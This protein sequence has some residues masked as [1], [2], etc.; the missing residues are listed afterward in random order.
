M[1]RWKTHAVFHLFLFVLAVVVKR[2]CG[3]KVGHLDGAWSGGSHA[4]QR[5]GRA[6]PARAR[7]WH[8]RRRGRGVRRRRGRGR[9]KLE[10]GNVA[11]QLHRQAL[12]LGSNRGRRRPHDPR[13]ARV[14]KIEIKGPYEPPETGPL[15]EMTPDQ[16]EKPL[17]RAASAWGNSCPSSTPGCAGSAPGASRGHLTGGCPTRPPC[18]GLRG[19]GLSKKMSAAPS[20]MNA[21]HVRSVPLPRGPNDASAPLSATLPIRLARATWARVCVAHADLASVRRVKHLATRQALHVLSS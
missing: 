11:A 5:G 2:D 20:A 16:I 21:Q 19:V 1:Q 6:V 13:G 9:Q 18:A 7:G 4:H 17:L 3:R 8:V 14:G 10:R 12:G 15:A